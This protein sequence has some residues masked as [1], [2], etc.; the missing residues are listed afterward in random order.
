MCNFK[1]RAG[2]TDNGG[3]ENQNAYI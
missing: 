1:S 2:Y 3:Y